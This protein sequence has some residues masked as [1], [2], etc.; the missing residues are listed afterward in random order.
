MF[1][2]TALTV[3]MFVNPL[4][5]LLHVSDD[6]TRIVSGLFVGSTDDFGFDDDAA[7]PRPLPGLAAEFSINV[8]GLSGAPGEF[9]ALAP[10]RLRRRASTLHSWP[11]RPAN[12]NLQ[13]RDH[14]GYSVI[15]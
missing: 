12:E 10:F 6:E 1:Y 14:S 8:F 5:T 2:V 4:W 11:S 7:L 15:F 9:G 3:D 13:V